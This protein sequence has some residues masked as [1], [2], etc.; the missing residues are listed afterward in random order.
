MSHEDDYGNTEPVAYEVARYALRTFVIRDG[1]LSSVIKGGGHWNEGVCEA[2]CLDEDHEAPAPGCRCGIYGALS[3]QTLYSQYPK[4]TSR[5]VAVIAAEGKTMLG[6]VGLRT[7]AARVVAYWCA[8]P[9]DQHR[10]DIAICAVQ[11][12]GARRFHDVEVMA[13]LYHMGGQQ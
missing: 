3:L 10:D 11:C 12:P 13:R 5:I 1:Q 6:T 9:N 4:A 7:A 8:E 2:V